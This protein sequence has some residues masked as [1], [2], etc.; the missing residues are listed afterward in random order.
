MAVVVPL[1]LDAL[2]AV[3]STRWMSARL[4]WSWAGR[5]E[6]P[7]VLGLAG[8]GIMRLRWDGFESGEL[9]SREELWLADGEGGRGRVLIDRWLALNIVAATLRFGA[10]KVL[11]RL[12]AAEKGVL[13]GH[14][15]AL[16]TFTGGRVVVDLV[17]GATRL[18]SV[19][20]PAAIGLGFHAEA[21]GA[22]G[23]VR[24]EVP[25]A[26]L[27]TASWPD[28]STAAI[29]KVAAR[30]E[31]T[32]R[33]SVAET[34]LPASDFAHA[35]RGDIVVFDGADFERAVAPDITVRVR[36]GE[37]EADGEVRSDGAF[38]FVGPFGRA[39]KDQEATSVGAS[40]GSGVVKHSTNMA[41]VSD[42]PKLDVLAG[43]P[44]EVVAE[45]GR[46][47]LRGDELLGLERG[48]VRAF[49]HRGAGRVDLV[50]GGRAWARG[51]LVN[52]DGE[53]GVRITEMVRA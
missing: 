22:S 43:A 33:I 18:R 42:D 30:L 7:I 6:R 34:M 50:V 16:L 3:T 23:P 44:V 26:W 27:T 4:P 40:R 38:I 2:P 51:E 1:S 35:G 21:A 45:L 9:A 20:V 5:L 49:G 19:P 37:H 25:P 10:P 29:N 24:L 53:L 12:G 28:A 36:V 47:T 15:A 11:R 39:R 13:A 17:G 41:A 46:V 48:S 8:T 32:A 31:T 52:V 14:L